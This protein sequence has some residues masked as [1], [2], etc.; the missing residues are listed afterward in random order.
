MLVELTEQIVDG[1]QHR[2]GVWLDRD[3]V[4][5]P[6]VLEPER[7]HDR[8]EG[9]RRGLVSAHL[10]PGG[11]GPDAVGV[12]DDG[13][14]EPEHSLLHLAQDSASSAECRCRKHAG[15]IDHHPEQ[16]VETLL[17]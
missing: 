7:G 6:Q 15:H 9:C 12:S 14:G 1:V 11:V 13:G 4:P 2:G 16:D 5:S 17:L 3:P 10:E 8:R